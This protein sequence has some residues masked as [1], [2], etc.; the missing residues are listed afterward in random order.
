MEPKVE[1]PPLLAEG[2]QDIKLDELKVIF[3]TPFPKTTT[4]T[5]ILRIFK[6]WIKGVKKL[7]VKCEIWIDGSF[8]TEKV[9]PKDIDVVLF[10]SSKDNY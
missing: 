4:R 10:I 7:N 8:A 9:D 1:Y 6:H 5:K 2:F 3:L